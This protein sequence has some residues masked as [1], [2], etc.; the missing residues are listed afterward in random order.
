MVV[1][2][3]ALDIR[4]VKKQLMACNDPKKRRLIMTELP[5]N[6]GA[7]SVLGQHAAN[8]CDDTVT[9]RELIANM[10]LAAAQLDDLEDHILALERAKPTH[11]T[12]AF[13]D[14]AIQRAEH[15]ISGFQ[16][17]FVARTIQLQRHLDATG[18][19][20]KDPDRWAAL[21]T[22]SAPDGPPKLH[23]VE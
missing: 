9:R 8:G 1:L 22:S 20:T 15:G 13:F 18:S 2:I 16:V 14:G 23:D 6:G 10:D 4:S 11:R 21:L 3:K 7:P 5:T 12:A 19:G 17:S